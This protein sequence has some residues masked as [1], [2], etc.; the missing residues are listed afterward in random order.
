MLGYQTPL[1]N[2]ARLT[3]PVLTLAY[4]SGKKQRRFNMP[5]MIYWSELLMMTRLPTMI[6][7]RRDWCM[8]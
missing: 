4:V 1:A 7:Q 3:D 2:I 6:M 8:A 5:K